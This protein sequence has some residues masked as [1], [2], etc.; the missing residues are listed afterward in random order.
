MFLSSIRESNLSFKSMIN[1]IRSI[2]FT[3]QLL[4]TTWFLRD[5]AVDDRGEWSHL[6]LANP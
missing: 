4:A 1:L 2:T 5:P 3:T 6:M